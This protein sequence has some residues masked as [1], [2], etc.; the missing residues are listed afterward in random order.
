MLEHTLAGDWGIHSKTTQK[1]NEFLREIKLEG[2]DLLE[3]IYAW[4]ICLLA[5]LL[6]AGETDISELPCLVNEFKRR[7]Y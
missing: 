4:G 1:A 3:A 7:K 2:V 6:L 5:M